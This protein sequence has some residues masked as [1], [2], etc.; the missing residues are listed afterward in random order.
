MHKL[1]LNYIKLYFDTCC[2]ESLKVSL[3]CNNDF[4][5]FSV[6]RIMYCLQT[7][8]WIGP[9]NVNVAN[10]GT[11]FKAHLNPTDFRSKNVTNSW[12]IE[13]DL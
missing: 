9:K 8:N 10:I 2:L 6:A 13:S 12:S 3:N 4:L 1:N 11:D 5:N 7:T